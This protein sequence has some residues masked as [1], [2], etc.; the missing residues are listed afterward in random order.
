M[1]SNR[2]QDIVKQ[3]LEA[4]W[5]TPVM[6]VRF[7]PPQRGVVGFWADK[8]N[9]RSKL[10]RALKSARGLKAIAFHTSAGYPPH[11]ARWANV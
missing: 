8:A 2:V 6:F 10:T 3:A 11:R 1:T 4:E 5:P 7:D 9:I